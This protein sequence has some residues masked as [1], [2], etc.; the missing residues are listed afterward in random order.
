MNAR[1]I[2]GLAR[3]HHLVLLRAFIMV[4]IFRIALTF[5]RYRRIARY[6]RVRHSPGRKQLGP[7]IIAWA[8]RHAA[9]PVPFAHC[10]TQALALQYLLARQ[11]S[12]SVIRVGMLAGGDGTIDAHAWVLHEG[13]VLIGGNDRSLSSYATLVDLRPA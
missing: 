1:R 4:L 12:E 5:M 3:R 2:V 6:I 13:Q 10:L 11:G 7:Y 8:V 9:R